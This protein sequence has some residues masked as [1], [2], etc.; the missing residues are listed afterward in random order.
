MGKFQQIRKEGGSSVIAITS[1][2]PRD[3]Q[4]VDITKV[5]EKGDIVTLK[6]EKVK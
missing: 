2:I 1:F 6:I 3:W 5:S 4:A